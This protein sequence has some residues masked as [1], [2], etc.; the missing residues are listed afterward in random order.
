MGHIVSSLHLLKE[1][2]FVFMCNLIFFCVGLCLFSFPH[3]LNFPLYCF[4]QN[5]FC[6]SYFY[7]G[8][9]CFLSLLFIRG[10]AFILY[11]AGFIC[12]IDSLFSLDFCYVC[13]LF[14]LCLSC[15]CQYVTKRGRN[16]WN[17]GILFKK[18]FKM[19]CLGG[20]YKNLLMY[21][22]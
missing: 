11:R 14:T 17:V 5:M 3:L 4:S 13:F 7:R 6:F 16:R 19:F 10:V 1:K 15:V 20:E 18:V 2:I 9:A 22:T 12:L 8:E 21:L